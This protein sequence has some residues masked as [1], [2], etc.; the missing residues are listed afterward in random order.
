MKRA[1]NRPPTIKD[2]TLAVTLSKE[3]YEFYTYDQKDD[4]DFTNLEG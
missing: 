2:T 3:A 4:I 1:N